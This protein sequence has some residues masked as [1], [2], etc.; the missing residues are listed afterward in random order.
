M[1]TF[2]ASKSVCCA[3]SSFIT[4]NHTAKMTASAPAIA[5]PTLVAVAPLPTS[6][7][8]ASAEEALSAA[9]TTGS[10]PVARCPATVLPMLPT[11]MTAVAILPPF[12]PLWFSHA[13]DLGVSRA[14][15]QGLLAEELLQTGNR[16]RLSQL[17]ADGRS[18]GHPREVGDAHAARER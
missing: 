1:T 14:L 10:Q 12:A 15:D 16:S 2:P 8:A 17:G 13:N 4:S 3:M 9:S 18:A 11:P 6:S 5:S 7:A